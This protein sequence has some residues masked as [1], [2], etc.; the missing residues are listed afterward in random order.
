MRTG[1][2]LLGS[3]DVGGQRPGES[4]PGCQALCWR[5]PCTDSLCVPSHPIWE[6]LLSSLYRWGN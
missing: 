3:Q 1:L 5:S 2:G 4:G 6:I